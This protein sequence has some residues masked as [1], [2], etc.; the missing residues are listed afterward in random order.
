VLA[1]IADDTAH[2]HDLF[3]LDPMYRL[4]WQG[5]STPAVTVEADS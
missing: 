4:T 1:L 5:D 3:D 2:L